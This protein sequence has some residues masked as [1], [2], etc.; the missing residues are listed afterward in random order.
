[1]D[2]I[3]Q[4]SPVQT[5]RPTQWCRAACSRWSCLLL[6]RWLAVMYSSGWRWH[7]RIISYYT[8]SI[9]LSG[10][11]CSAYLNHAGISPP[12]TAWLS[13]GYVFSGRRE[14]GERHPGCEMSASHPT[15][16]G[17][18]EASA[19]W[20]HLCPPRKQ[21][22]RRAVLLFISLADHCPAVIQRDWLSLS[23]SLCVWR[24]ECVCVN[25][26]QGICQ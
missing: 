1:M 3:L 21:G 12:G 24:H 8:Q 25:H 11:I 2:C 13:L 22:C 5:S 15:H 10:V 18:G 26:R 14:E 17:W 19:E 4:C 23:L 9:T 7:P 6:L 16:L 20:K